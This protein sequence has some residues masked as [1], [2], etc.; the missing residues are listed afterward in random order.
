MKRCEWVSGLDLVNFAVGGEVQV[1]IKQLSIYSLKWQTSFAS[2]SEKSQI[3]VS[4][5]HFACLY[6]CELL[7]TSPARR[8]HLACSGLLS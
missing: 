7:D 8:Y 6:V 2:L 1:P 3:R 5:L 4:C